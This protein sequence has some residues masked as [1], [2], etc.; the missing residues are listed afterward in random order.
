MAKRWKKEEI[1]YLK[2]YAKQRTLEELAARYQVE[3]EAVEAK[4]SEL[5]LQTADGMGKIDLATDP[6]VKA[7]GKA[8][9]A[10]HAGKWAEARKLLER[11]VAESDLPEVVERAEQY[12]SVVRRYAGSAPS[13]DDPYLEAV[14]LH[15]QGDLDGAEAIC[16]KGNR[17]DTDARFAYL[18]ASIAALRGDFD[19]AAVRLET[20]IELNPRNRIQAA[21]DLDFEDMREQADYADLFQ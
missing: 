13:S 4:L 5:G 12:L 7:Y 15:N 10:A 20:A 18:A 8:L 21:E 17:A 3:A 19:Q 16:K 9:E 6:H 1:T 11:V 2:R 14:V